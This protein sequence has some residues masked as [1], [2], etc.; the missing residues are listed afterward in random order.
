MSNL[1]LVDRKS[2]PLPP[3]DFNDGGQDKAY[4]SC[5]WLERQ[6]TWGLD[7]N[8]Q[9]QG[10]RG[11]MSGMTPCIAARALGYAMRFA[12]CEEGLKAVV[13]DIC[14]CEQSLGKLAELA[15]LYVYG[16]CRI[17]K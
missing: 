17:C 12:P 14:A 3:N 4:D 1:P 2:T 5:L 9:D 8:V 13:D 10:P 16:L 7:V 6:Q 11:V 15:R